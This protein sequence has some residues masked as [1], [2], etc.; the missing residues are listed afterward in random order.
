MP[1][2][3]TDALMEYLLWMFIIYVFP[4]FISAALVTTVLNS[5]RARRIFNIGIDFIN[6]KVNKMLLQIE[7]VQTIEKLR[8][9]AK[10]V[11]SEAVK[12]SE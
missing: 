6:S 2:I 4:T 9:I 8:K 7:N 11:A 12:G 1:S 5:E 3:S 10:E